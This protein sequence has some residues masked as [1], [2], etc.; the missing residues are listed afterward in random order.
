MVGIGTVLA[1]DPSL[2]VKN[3]DHRRERQRSGKPEPGKDRYRQRG[4]D[5]ARCCGAHQRGGREG[6]GRF[7]S[8]GPGAGQGPQDTGNGHYC[9]GSS[10]GSRPRVRRTRGDGHPPSH[11]RRR[12]DT[13]RRAYPGP[14]LSTRSIPLSVTLLSAERMRRR[15]RTARAGYG[16]QILPGSCSRT[17]KEWITASSFTGRYNSTEAVPRKRFLIFPGRHLPEPGCQGSSTCTQK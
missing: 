3:P 16:K 14:A 11:G 5:T 4:A 12:G 10:G 1:D 13:D 6:G 15:P 8:C 2:T 7:W 9:R 17:R